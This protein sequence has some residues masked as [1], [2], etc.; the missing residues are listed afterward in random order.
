VRNNLNSSSKVTQW[1]KVNIEGISCQVRNFLIHEEIL[2][3]R[4]KNVQNNETMCHAQQQVNYLQGQVLVGRYI[5]CLVHNFFIDRALLWVYVE[6][7][8]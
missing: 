1:L 2:K 7:G 8:P 4:G 6:S 5:L 3:I